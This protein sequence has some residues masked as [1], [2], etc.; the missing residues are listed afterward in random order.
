[1]VG[2]VKQR[3]DRAGPT[4]RFCA[5]LTDATYARVIDV[6]LAEVNLYT[7]RIPRTKA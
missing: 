3:A 4:H 1:M 5:A 6:A 2:S 7:I